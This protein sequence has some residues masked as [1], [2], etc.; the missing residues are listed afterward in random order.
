MM[1]LIPRDLV[2]LR[3]YLKHCVALPFSTIKFRSRPANLCPVEQLSLDNFLFH[4]LSI[5]CL[6]TSYMCIYSLITCMSILP[7]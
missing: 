1:L 4:T 7:Y 5:K 6:L 2:S 3:L